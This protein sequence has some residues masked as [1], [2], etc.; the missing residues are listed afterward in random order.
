MNREM[1]RDRETGKRSRD[2]EVPSE[3][4]RQREGVASRWLVRGRRVVGGVGA[5]EGGR[6]GRRVCERGGGAIDRMALVASGSKKSR[7]AESGAVGKAC[8]RATSG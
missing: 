8:I 7:R 5:S 4:K 3:R 2:S 6:E 1:R